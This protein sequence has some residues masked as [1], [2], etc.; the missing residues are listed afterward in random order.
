MPEAAPGTFRSKF[1]GTWIDRFDFEDELRERL[2]FGRIPGR[3]EA[4]IRRFERDGFIVLENAA[5][6]EEIARFESAISSAFRAGHPHLICQQPG[7]STPRGVTAGLGRRGTRIVDSYAVLPEALDLLSSPRLIEFLTVILEER[8]KLFQSL[9]FDMG[10]EQGLHQD[11]AYVVVDRPRE[12]I[13]CWIALEDVVPGSGELQYMVGSHRLPDFDFGGNKK[14]WDIATDRAD[15]HDNW[16]RWILE[17]GARRGYAIQKFFAKRGDILIWH[18]DLAHGG[19][20]IARPDVTRK[21]LVGHYCPESALPHYVKFAANRAA[22]VSHRGISC[23]SWHYD[24]AALASPSQ[25]K[26]FLDQLFAK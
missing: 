5:A 19:S 16:A 13:A 20:P 12:L 2:R 4:D 9:S 17:E 6:E 11:T 18:A 24:L 21:S 15:S 1:G 14:H 25:K 10:S 7:S 22:T 23:C 8:P 26:P 3:L